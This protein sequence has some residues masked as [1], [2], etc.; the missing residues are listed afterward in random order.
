MRCADAR[1]DCKKEDSSCA[2]YNT[3]FARWRH[4]TSITRILRGFA[5]LCKLGIFLFKPHWDYQI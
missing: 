3:S 4:F 5:F 1:I 2:G